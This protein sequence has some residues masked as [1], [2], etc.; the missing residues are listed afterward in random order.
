MINATPI[1]FASMFSILTLVGTRK[2]YFWV[3]RRN[4]SPRYR[5]CCLKEDERMLFCILQQQSSFRNFFALQSDVMLACLA[6]EADIVDDI[7]GAGKHVS[8]RNQGTFFGL[9]LMSLLLGNTST[10]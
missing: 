2:H 5:Q 3:L 1:L 8:W 9:T 4:L 10:H 6:D 7:I